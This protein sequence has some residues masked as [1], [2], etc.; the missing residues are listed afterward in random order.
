MMPG[1][2]PALALI[3]IGGIEPD[4]GGGDWVKAVVLLALLHGGVVLGELVAVASCPPAT[5][6]HPQYWMES[7]VGDWTPPPS[8]Y[9]MTQQPL[10][11]TSPSK[12]YSTQLLVL[13]EL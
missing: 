13:S 9:H 6:R 1:F 8:W 5:L 11:C 4:L 7:A 12:A 3:L 10:S 2:A